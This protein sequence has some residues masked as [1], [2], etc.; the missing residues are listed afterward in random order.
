[1]KSIIQAVN[2]EQQLARERSLEIAQGDM[3]RRYHIS[4]EAHPLQAGLDA[5][6]GIADQVRTL[7]IDFPG[8]MQSCC[9]IIKLLFLYNNF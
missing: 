1:M 8:S 5:A 6:A 3:Q 9:F 2:Q 4:D 7:P